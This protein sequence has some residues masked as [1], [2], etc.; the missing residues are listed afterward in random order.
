M[1]ERTSR[2]YPIADA[3]LTTQDDIGRPRTI[4][5]KR[6]RFVPP[7]SSSTTMLQH[8]V[9]QGDRLDNIT[10]RYF[11]DPTQFWRIADA[12]EVMEPSELEAAPGRKIKIPVPGI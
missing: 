5:Y 2:Y 12:N 6:R 10:A 9:T 11:G 7:P 3:S 4:V 1:F 8:T